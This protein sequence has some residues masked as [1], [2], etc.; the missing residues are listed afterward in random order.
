M[1]LGGGKKQGG[2]GERSKAWLC[3]ESPTVSFPPR[4][5]LGE[6]PHLPEDEEEASLQYQLGGCSFVPVLGYF[7][8]FSDH[9]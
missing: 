3:S 2:L 7:R 1:S 5:G 6:L 4:R 9:F 8:L